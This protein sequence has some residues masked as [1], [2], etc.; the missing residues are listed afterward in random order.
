MSF[1]LCRWSELSA[2]LKK[3]SEK[4]KSVDSDG[5]VKSEGSS[6]GP[7]DLFEEWGMKYADQNKQG[8]YEFI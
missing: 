2:E 8:V 4:G 3:P 5:V 6:D 7:R 1:K